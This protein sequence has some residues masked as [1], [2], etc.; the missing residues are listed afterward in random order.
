M[1]LKDDVSQWAGPIQPPSPSELADR[2]ALGQLC[3]VYALGVDQRKFDLVLSVFTDD[4][5]LAGSQGMGPAKEYLPKVYEPATHYDSTQHNILNQYITI[6]G[7]EAL[8]WNYAVAYHMYEQSK[9]KANL[10]VGVIYKDKCRRT[11][12]GWQI[13]ERKA[14]LE[15]VQ[16]EV[17][18]PKS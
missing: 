14:T 11:P 4:A 9:G 3:K 1:P 17:V 13:F 12:K 7:D 8:V 16:G 5:Q 10:I 6:E 15:W 2:Y 18:R